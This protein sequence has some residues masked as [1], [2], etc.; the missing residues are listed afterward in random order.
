MPNKG[1]GNGGV[2]YP[3][4][5]EW[6]VTVK[7]ISNIAKGMVTIVTC[8]SHGI[9]LSSNQSTPR[10]DFSQVPGMKQINGQFGFVLEVPNENQVVIGISSFNFSNYIAPI[11][12]TWDSF[13]T[14]WDEENVPWDY[15]ATLRGGFMNVIVSPSPIDPLTNTFA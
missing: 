15:F 7:P 11:D 5:N 12:R 9:T 13:T 14:Q 8:P 6:T 4:A 1:A 3:S 2:T 10:V